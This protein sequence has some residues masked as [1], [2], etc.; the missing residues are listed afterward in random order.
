MKNERE[1]NNK[2]EEGVTIW[3]YSGKV[4]QNIYIP[5]NDEG[6]T[7]IDLLYLTQKRIFVIESKNYSGYIFG[8]EK[9][10]K[11]TSSLYAGKDWVGML[12][13]SKRKLIMLIHVRDAEESQF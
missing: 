11:W 7:E 8:N 5:Q 1:L 2:N 13:A 3:E 4:L 9:Y 12:K 10:S 6:T